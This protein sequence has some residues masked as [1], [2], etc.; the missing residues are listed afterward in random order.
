MPLINSNKHNKKSRM[1]R[2]NAAETLQ[3]AKYPSMA[4][5]ES[6]KEKPHKISTLVVCPLALFCALIAK[7]TVR[8]DVRLFDFLSDP[9]TTTS[10]PFIIRASS[11]GGD[12]QKP[13]VPQQCLWR[14]FTP[15]EFHKN[16][17]KSRN[18]VNY[19]VVVSE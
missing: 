2:Y 16:L 13:I 3:Y 4:N 9:F 14:W 1:K 12:R 11:R 10:S 7:T 5:Y 19:M 18:K 17:D 15:S 6:E 8:M